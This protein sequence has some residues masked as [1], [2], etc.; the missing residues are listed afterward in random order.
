MEPFISQSSVTV[1]WYKSVLSKGKGKSP[2]ALF[3]FAFSI[4][5]QRLLQGGVA[6]EEPQLY[7]VWRLL[8]TSFWLASY[9]QDAF[10][11]NYETCNL[12]LQKRTPVCENGAKGY[13]FTVSLSQKFD[14]LLIK[15][16]QVWTNRTDLSLSLKWSRF[17]KDGFEK[18]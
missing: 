10:F 5:Q 1:A 13:F 4:S 6:V 14:C 18:F 2:P 7:P 9:I 3:C 11:T 12:V 16:A 15:L 17:F 8:S